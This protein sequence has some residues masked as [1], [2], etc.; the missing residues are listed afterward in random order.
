M[1]KLPTA[2]LSLTML[3]SL[4]SMAICVLDTDPE[5]EGVQPVTLSIA[6]FTIKIDADAVASRIKAIAE[7]E[8]E[9]SGYVTYKCEKGEP[10]GK[11]TQSPLGAA[12]QDRMF[13]TNIAGIE[14]MPRWNNGVAYGKFPTVAK[15]PVLG[16]HSYP[17]ASFFS[18]DVYKTTERL[19]LSNPAGDVV[20]NG[21]IIAY[22][23]IN[24]DSSANYAQRLQ[25]GEIRIIS[26][27][28]CRLEGEKSVDFNIV[29][30]TDVTNGVKRPLE[31]SLVCITDYGNYTA[32]ASL[33]TQTPTSDNAYIQVTDSA[34][35]NDRLKI[36]VDDSSG[37]PLPVDASRA[38]VKSSIS[39]DTPAKFTWNATLLRASGAAL[40]E[41]GKFDAR[42]EIVLQ[43][44]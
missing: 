3:T 44:N 39:T 42:A 26:T 25:V 22:N 32:S 4:P 15:V 2:L 36:R 10:Y 7:Y 18:I 24:S 33:S 34:G 5:F 27:P 19:N 14:I 43:V 38:E 13:A 30:A 21:G 29:S 17:K 20:L 41:N 1:R 16:R 28:V 11:S 8:T 6:A 40:P 12:T 35:N 37:N 23:W 31:F 9:K